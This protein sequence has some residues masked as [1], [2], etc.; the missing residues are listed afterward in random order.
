MASLDRNEVMNRPIVGTVQITI[1]NT[2][3]RLT[4]TLDQVIFIA[5]ALR[6]P[7]RGI[8]GGCTRSPG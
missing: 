8:A 3:V 4:A 2:T 6:S 7:G 1:R 5:I